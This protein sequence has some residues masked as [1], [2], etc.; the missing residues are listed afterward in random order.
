MNVDPFFA[1][2]VLADRIAAFLA[3]YPDL[4]LELVTRDTP[5][6][7]IAD[8]FDLAVRFGEPAIGSLVARKLVDTRILTVASPAYLASRG[9]PAHPTDLAAHDCID[10]YDAAN[11]RPFEWEFHRRGEILPVKFR[12]RLLLSNS[13]TLLGACIAGAGVAQVLELGTR[14]Y[15]RSGVLVELFPEWSDERFPLYALF[16]SRRHRA[17][18][19]LAFVDFCEEMIAAYEA[20]ASG[21]AD[22]SALPSRNPR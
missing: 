2:I 20:E 10:F 7:L 11:G 21:S 9:K 6:D 16:P 18:K 17:A 15:L 5:G 12:S 8:G 13:D 14:A 19:V 1:R 3:R 4:A 22:R